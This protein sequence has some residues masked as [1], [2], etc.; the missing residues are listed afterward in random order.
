[1]GRGGDPDL[2]RADLAGQ[3][4]EL[5]RIARRRID[6]IFE[7]ADRIDARGAGFRRPDRGDLADTSEFFSISRPY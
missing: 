6:V 7:I 1:M 5:G 2:P 3:E 4:F